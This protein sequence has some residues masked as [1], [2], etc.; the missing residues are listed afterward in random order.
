MSRPGV[1][2]WERARLTEWKGLPRLSDKQEKI[3]S[4]VEKKV[5]GDT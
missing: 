3:L 1:T 2:A 5:F 4:A